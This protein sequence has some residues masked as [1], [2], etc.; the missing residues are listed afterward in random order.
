MKPTI[1][2]I[3]KAAGVS[4]STVSRA[5]HNNA[6]ISESVRARVQGIA[7]SMNFHPNQMARSLVNRKTRI[8][9]IVFPPD[10]GRSLGHPFYP[11]VLQGLGHVASE[12]R[13]HLLLGTGSEAVSSAETVEQ[14]VE[15]GYV[16][17]LIVLAA[18]DCPEEATSVPVVVIGRPL[19]PA[20][21]D[22][23]DTDNVKA[24]YAAARYLLERGHRRVAFI[25]YDKQYTVTTDRLKGYEKALGEAGLPLRADW[26]VSSRFLE[27]KTDTAQL[28]EIFGA[29]DRPTAV[30]SM[31]DSLSIGLAGFLSSVSLTVPDDVSIFSFNNTEAGRYHN[32]PLTSL[33]VDPYQLGVHAM[34]LML[35]RLKNRLDEPTH[36]EVP[37]TLVERQSVKALR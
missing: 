25:G 16:S 9:G 36:I 11:A 32:P 17:G 29:T 33:D 8:V 10:A 37:F 15:S 6:R 34:T 14:L 28:S 5:L 7:K 35:D 27:H 20:S 3:A 4:P 13:Y 31:D 24:G 18:E 30:V 23:V 26:V 21:C 2:D 1:K 19:A 22:S 12:R